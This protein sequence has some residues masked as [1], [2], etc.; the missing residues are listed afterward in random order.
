MKCQICKRRTNWNESFGHES[1]IVCP[2]CEY[3]L[4]QFF[5]KDWFRS[6]ELIM[7]LGELREEFE[8]EKESKK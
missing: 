1:F 3:R 8:K 6:I 7:T 4:R 2:K 5:G